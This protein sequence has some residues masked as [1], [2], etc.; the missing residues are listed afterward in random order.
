MAK[1]PSMPPEF[2]I[3]TRTFPIPEPSIQL[4]SQPCNRLRPSRVNILRAIAIEAII[5][6]LVHHKS[7]T[8]SCYRFYELT[9]IFLPDIG[10]HKW[11]HLLSQ[12]CILSY[13]QRP[14]TS[15]HLYSQSSRWSFTM[16]IACRNEYVITG[17][18]KLMPRFFMSLLMAI[19]TSETV[20]TS[21]GVFQ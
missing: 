19:E 6:D 1:Q 8:G 2:R 3:P 13:S 10:D 15:P 14:F 17:P 20:G 5:G 11:T 21:A 4:S 18:T 16:P 9:H 7:V 12:V